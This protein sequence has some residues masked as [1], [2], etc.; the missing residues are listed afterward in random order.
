VQAPSRPRGADRYTEDYYGVAMAMAISESHDPGTRIINLYASHAPRDI[1]YAEDIRR[2]ALGRWHFVTDKGDYK[3]TIKTVETFDE[4]LGGF[5]HAVLTT[6]GM[7]LKNNIYRD[8]TLLVVDIGGYTCDVV[9]VDPNGMI[10]DSSL[11]STITGVLNISSQFEAELRSLYRDMFKGVG[12]ID[13][14]RIE[15]AMLTGIYR[16][17]KLELDCADIAQESI[18]T[19]VNDI[20]DVMRAAGSVANYDIVL[21]TGGG[22]ALV[23]DALRRAEQR[24]DFE[25]VEPER[26][27]MRYANVFGGAK[28]F[29]MLKRLGVI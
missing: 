5:N 24:V 29:N 12:D 4:P 16:F 20:K 15:Q 2:A 18:Q 14:R 28:M 7:P 26:E 6:N 8:S 9:A 13:E 25:L 11:Q 23:V 21:L 10:D 3:I 1:E 27:L 17:G 19:L 22:S